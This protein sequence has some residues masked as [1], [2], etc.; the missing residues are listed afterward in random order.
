MQLNPIVKKDIR[1]A[2]RSIKLSLG[3]CIYELCLALI[4][5]LT[6]SIIGLSTNNNY[7]YPDNIFQSMIYIFPVLG[8]TQVGIVALIT[9]ILTASAISGE[10]ERQ[11]FDIM[12]TTC[13][14][15]F[16]IIV[17]KVATAVI[18]VLLYVVASIPIMSLSFVIGGITWMTLFWYLVCIT[19]LAI[20]AGSIG[21]FCSSLCSKTIT[22]V[23]LT[24]CFYA[25]IAGGTCLPM[26][27][28]LIIN[29][30]D[31]T[32]SP[33][34]LFANPIFFFEE[35]FMLT[36]NNQSLFG[37]FNGQ[38]SYF[39]SECGVITGLLSHGN[40][41]LLISG[42]CLL[43]LSLF[44]ILAAA[45]TINPLFTSKKKIKSSKKANKEN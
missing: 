41:W 40:L 27:I 32:E 10:R 5:F 39:G 24:F 14:T 13:L 6:L 45:R 23:I 20:L 29:K 7:Y 3:V 26:L 22:S 34:F 15:P 1:V 38:K 31:L 9:P 16:H 30:G 37:G 35:F 11:T 43:L 19:I 8:I 36:M 33:L 12:L 25:L 17:G 18:R 4:L 44:F 42:F 21:I 28:D 2:S